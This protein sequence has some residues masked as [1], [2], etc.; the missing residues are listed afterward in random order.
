MRLGVLD[1]GSNTVR[2]LVASPAGQAGLEPILEEREHLFLGEDV[3]RIGRISAA[4]MKRAVRCA[5]AYAQLAREAGVADLAVVVTAPGRQS[6]NGDVLVERLAAAT[7]AHVRLLTPDEEG[8]LAFAGAL[9]AAGSPPDAVAV[10]DVGGGSTEVVVGTVSGGPAWTRSLDLGAVRLTERFLPDDPPRRR[11]LAAA[12]EEAERC[13]ASFTP[14]LPR[15]ALAAGGTARALRKLVGRT[16]GAEELEAAVAML[17]RRP[18]K[19]IAKTFEV[20]P[21]RARTLA[22]GA[23]LLLVIE[24]RVGVPLV[25][26]RAGLREGA[27]LDLLARAEAAAA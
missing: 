2:L 13:L 20:H 23:I 7:G 18:S 6:A 19:R 3:E 5:G 1:I 17:S 9:A 14:P 15:T 16:L 12:E 24:R 8:H 10:C 11:G 4:K 25:V 27:V 21:R 22:A 26:S